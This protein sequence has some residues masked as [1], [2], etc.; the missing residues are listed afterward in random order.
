M[1]SS[2]ILF[3]PIDFGHGCDRPAMSRMLMADLCP[4]VNLPGPSHFKF[5][6]QEGNVYIEDVRLRLGRW[7]LL[8]PRCRG[9]LAGCPTLLLLLRSLRVRAAPPRLIG[10]ETR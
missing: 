2:F 4:A 6:T 8:G 1:G 7:V 5:T 9:I 10:R 3:L